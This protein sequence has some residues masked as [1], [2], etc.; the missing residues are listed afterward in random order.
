MGVGAS[1]ETL[2]KRIDETSELIEFLEKVG[3]TIP[4]HIKLAV[5]AMKEGKQIA[6]SAEE[7]SA[8]LSK[9]AK[10]M[11]D[12]CAQQFPYDDGDVWICRATEA[13][14]GKANVSYSG[15]VN[16]VLNIE[17]PKSAA[18][19]YWRN[20]RGALG[21]VLDEIKNGHPNGLVRKCFLPNDS[22]FKL[23]RTSADQRN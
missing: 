14:R 6:I 10:E 22:V 3:V 21:C 19:I 5:G 8:Y 11:E 7:A 18:A 16:A 23:P 20:K 9:F 17:N 13:T 2:K 1:P 12:S 4:K 15:R